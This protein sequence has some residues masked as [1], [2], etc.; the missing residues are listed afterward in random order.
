MDASHP[1]KLD[2]VGARS[3]QV[4]ARSTQVLAKLARTE[5]ARAAHRLRTKD[6]AIRAQS[7]IMG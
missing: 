3:A 7:T 5:A 6:E 4:F 2:V 1:Y